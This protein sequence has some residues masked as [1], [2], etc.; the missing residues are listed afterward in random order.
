M[1]K[2][3][4]FR[5]SGKNESRKDSIDKQAHELDDLSE[6]G[7]QPGDDVKAEH[8]QG[9][10]PWKA[11]FFFTTK[12]HLTCFST[13]MAFAILSG[14]ASP[15]AALL[16]GKAFQGFASVADGNELVK[17]ETK[18]VF[19]LLGIG[20]GSWLLHFVFFAAWVAFGELQANNARDRLF[21]GMLVKEIEWYD[22]RKNGVGALIPRLQV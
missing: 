18:Y 22:L 5:R 3:P 1:P 21:N 16:T 8:V 14:L 20:L 7:K 12:A 17:K 9:A 13:A 2:F 11:L 15:A 19:Y 10:A 4:N 6:K